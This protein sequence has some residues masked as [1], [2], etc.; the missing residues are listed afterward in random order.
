MCLIIHNNSIGLVPKP[1]LHMKAL[2][3]YQISDI[4][5][6][7]FEL[8]QCSLFL[9]TS[10]LN[11]PKYSTILQFFVVELVLMLKILENC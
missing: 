1:I 2:L 4:K 9:L 8:S 10:L 7:I 11:I 3:A 5:N 6:T